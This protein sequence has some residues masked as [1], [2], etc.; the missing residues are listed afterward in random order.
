MEK[1]CAA[2]C[3]L[4]AVFAFSHAPLYG[5]MDP[6]VKAVIEKVEKDSSEGN[7]FPK[8]AVD[9]VRN[10]KKSLQFFL[11]HLPDL[12]VE[13]RN[14]VEEGNVNMMEELQERSLDP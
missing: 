11:N 6:D 4:S 10:S 13:R 3:A 2:L 12:T 8:A 14:H 1:L 7:P 5:A 9:L